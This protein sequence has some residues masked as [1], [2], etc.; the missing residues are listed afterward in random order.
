MAL[1]D[2]L[3]GILRA[4][5]PM[6]AHKTDQQLCTPPAPGKWSPKEVLGHLIDSAYNNHRRF[7]LAQQQDH[8]RFS[9]YDQEDWVVTNNYANRE[10][11]EVVET[12]FVVQRHL[13]HAIASLPDDLLDRETTE[14]EFDRMA[15]RRLQAGTP[16]TL[17]YLV[18]D[19]CFHLVHHLKQIDP[20]FTV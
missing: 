10:A 12:F 14:H 17:R 1:S 6:I 8:L 20:S 5:A 13:V 11:D 2:D 7:I 18:E 4:A 19:Y 16:S 15:M 9:G 3:L